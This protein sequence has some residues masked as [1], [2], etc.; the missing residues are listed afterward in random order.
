MVPPHHSIGVFGY[1]SA[2]DFHNFLV[3][4]RCTEAKAIFVVNTSKVAQVNMRDLTDEFWVVPQHLKKRFDLSRYN[5]LP[6]GGLA[7]DCV[8]SMVDKPELNDRLAPAELKSY[9]FK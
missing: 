7:D 8:H 4:T 6:C 9:R 5:E 3:Q 2:N 1:F